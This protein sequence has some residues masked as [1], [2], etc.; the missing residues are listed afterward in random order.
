M[1]KA[2]AQLTS[3]ACFSFKYVCSSNVIVAVLFVFSPV[4]CSEC[5]VLNAFDTLKISSACS[6]PLSPFVHNC[7]CLCA[8]VCLAIQQCA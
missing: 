4:S 3:P 1:L 5:D 7:S 2:S 6:A 8:A